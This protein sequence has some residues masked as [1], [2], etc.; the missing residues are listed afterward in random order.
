MGLDAGKYC[1]NIPQ[2]GKEVTAGKS[3]FIQSLKTVKYRGL[4]LLFRHKRKGKI[5]TKFV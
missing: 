1:S 2:R 5:L 4:L 3:L